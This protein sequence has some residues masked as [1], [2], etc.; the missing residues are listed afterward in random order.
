MLKKQI[1]TSESGIL[2]RYDKLDTKVKDVIKSL[3]KLEKDKICNLAG[4][5]F[6]ISYIQINKDFLNIEKYEILSNLKD[7]IGVYVF[8]DT[9]N[10]PVYIGFSGKG[11]INSLKTRLS[12]QLNGNPTNSNLVKK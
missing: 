9:L 11:K 1:N 2:T 5:G 7:K 12:F 3:Y 4:S 10:I 6:S 8:L